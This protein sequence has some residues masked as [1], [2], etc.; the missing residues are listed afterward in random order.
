M[1][2]VLDTRLLSVVTWYHLSFLAVSVAM[3]GT[4]AGAVFVFVAGELFAPERAV[5]LL[6]GVG[7]AFAIALPVSHIA[8]LVIPFPSV[9]GG[10]P[11]E[12]AALGIATL[13]LTIPFVIAGVAV[14]LALTRT[15]GRIGI[16]Y[17]ADLI[18][19][20]LGCLAIIW[21]LDLTDITS[22]A[23]TTG[24]IAAI[25]AWCFARYAGI[26]GVMASVT[27]L[28]L[29]AAGALNARA[30]RPLGV[31]YPKSRSL[32]LDQRAIDFSDWNAHSNVIVRAPSQ[33]PPFL[34]GP[35]RNAPTAPVTMALAAIDGDA[36]TVITKWDGQPSSLDWVQHD[37][38]SLPYRLRNGDVA[39]I[40]VGGGRDVLTAIWAANRSV[41]G[42]E[43][44]GV[45]VGALRNRYRDFAGIA[46][47]PGVT[48]VHDEARSYLTRSGR[49]F[50]VLQ[51]SLIDTWAATGA[52]AFT[53]SENGLYTV[54]AW[55]VFLR[56]LSP[57]GI[58]SVSRWF[59]PDAP[60]ETTRLLALG[61]ASL[62]EFGVQEPRQHLILTT[63]ER[64]ATLMASPAPFAEED[65]ARL[66]AVAAEHD[67][68]VRLS[69]WHS[70]ADERLARI[71]TARTRDALE[72]ATRDPFFDFSPPT[73]RRPFFFNMLKPA[74]FFT[75]GAPASVGV[76]SGN[77]LAT[78]TLIALAGV[79]GVLV[80]A[81][82]LWPLAM[83]GRP[84]LP[85]GVFGSAVGYFALI[86]LAFMLVQIPFLQTFSVYLGHPTYTF[87]I[88]LFLMILSA[89]F[90][91]LASERVDVHSPRLSLLPVA[92]AGAI[93][94]ATVA[95]DP[96]MSAT[97]GWGLP[98]RT[99]VVAVLVVPLAFALGFCFPIGLRLIGRH[100]DTVTAWMWGVNGACGVMASILAVMISMW[101]GIQANLVAAATLY[102]LLLVPMRR[103]AAIRPS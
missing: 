52:G 26:R 47:H 54:D 14:T 82:I 20:A 60:S 10:A 25:G 46:T 5:R 84:S 17:G 50:D 87:S 67:F 74:A 99:L 103:L 2:E 81:I 97:V 12:L 49:R 65:R 35:G 28:A 78:R 55:Q 53:L 64:V 22:T 19:A 51:M 41:T 102:A 59:D 6:P 70:A 62:L 61:V 3:L 18:G 36:G 34:W 57:N 83:V 4:A 85:A 33:G 32:W 90:G 27:A 63:R 38:T 21:L 79:A 66:E 76:V 56:S 42:I 77:L 8:N 92:I 93:L 68:T 39:V 30:D 58:F 94:V 100:S 91:S 40:G 15:G 31:M 72:Q 9:R 71:V 69:P 45:L 96:L 43:I 95:L 75:G 29:L 48:L 86:G 24:G 37:I 1:L 11:A 88:I 7:L 101:L 89:G 73:D 23:F 44:N 80:L 98:G 16:L 13:A